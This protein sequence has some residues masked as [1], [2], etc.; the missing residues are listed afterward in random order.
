[1]S[2][3][4]PNRICVDDEE[5]QRSR[6]YSV[7]HKDFKASKPS[8]RL[9][10]VYHRKNA[11]EYNEESFSHIIT[12]EDGQ[13]RYFCS[14]RCSFVPWVKPIIT[15]ESREDIFVWSKPH[16]IQITKRGKRKTKK[17]VRHYLWFK[18]QYV[19]ILAEKSN[20]FHLVT[21]YPT[22]YTD[23]IQKFE[24]ELAKEF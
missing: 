18:P 7:F 21:A 11:A 3:W 6:A 20:N 19:V 15:N 4:L 22:D 5:I 24:A 16:R 10:P 17:E 1:M 8:F 9:L 13:F 14:N 23:T 12:Q 2:D